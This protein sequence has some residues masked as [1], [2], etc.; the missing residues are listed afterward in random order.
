MNLQVEINN[1]GKLGVGWYKAGV[2]VSSSDTWPRKSKHQTK[3]V[4]SSQLVKLGSRTQK[5]IEELSE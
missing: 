3:R 2:E 5:P 1:L 4:N